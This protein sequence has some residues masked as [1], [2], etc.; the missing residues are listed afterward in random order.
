[1]NE[2]YLNGPSPDRLIIARLMPTFV[3]LPSIESVTRKEKSETQVVL[4][5]QIPQKIDQKS[6]AEPIIAKDKSETRV[7]SKAQIPEKID[8]G[9]KYRETNRIVTAVP[10]ARVKSEM[11]YLLSSLDKM[12]RLGHMRS[13]ET[14]AKDVD[15]ARSHGS[16]WKAVASSAKGPDKVKSDKKAVL[17]FLGEWK[18]AWEQREPDRFMKMYHPDF[19]HEGMNYE[20]LLKVKKNFFRKY[21]TIRVDVDRVE[22]RKAQ[23]R[24]LVR[25]VQSF[26]G[27]SYRDK[28]WKS[29][30]LAGGKDAGFRIVSEGWTALSGSASD[31]DT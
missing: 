28:G 31:S 11:I 12:A 7:A 8:R 21:R 29:M 26:Q 24:V 1:M 9:S 23:G 15:E 3:P 19:E 22:I 13:R 14:N 25:F 4:N 10:H 20:M 16:E 5:T 6:K 30:V 27:D 18:L 17:A 2:R